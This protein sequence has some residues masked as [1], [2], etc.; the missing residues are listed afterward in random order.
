M[1]PEAKGVLDLALADTKPGLEDPVV[2]IVHSVA[3]ILM[4]RPAQGLQD[5][6]N[7]AI[8]TNYD[9]QLWKA[10]ADARQGKWAEARE[11]FKNVEFAITSLP[12]DLQRIVIAEAMRASLEV[13][14]YSGAAKRGSDLEVIGLPPE[15][16]PAIAVL[17]GRLAEGLG[18]EQDALDE[19]KMAADSADRAAATEASLLRIALLQKRDEINQAEALRQ[20]ETLSM[21]W[22]GDGLEVR[23]LE[24]MARIYSDTG[25]YGESFAAARTATRLQPNSELVAAGPGRGVGAVRAALSRR[26]R[27]TIFRR[28]TRSGC[29]TTIA[30]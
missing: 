25:R 16:Q 12:I 2:L 10:L 21:M 9:S 27:V 28:S 19:Y 5:L 8:G 26:R 29:F 11:K 20:L 30:N 13:R 18:H 15:M 14:D 6:A 22:R 4:G 24:M 23:A 17:R 3:S 7:P 1:Y